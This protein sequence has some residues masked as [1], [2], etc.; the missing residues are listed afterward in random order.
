MNCE[1][2]TTFGAVCEKME[3]E[4]TMIEQD[5]EMYNVVLKRIAGIGKKENA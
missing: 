3:I 4:Y 1:I 2:C 5:V